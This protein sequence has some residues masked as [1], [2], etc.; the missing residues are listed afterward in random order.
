MTR[1]KQKDRRPVGSCVLE[2]LDTCTH[3]ACRTPHSEWDFDEFDVQYVA[4]LNERRDE[5]EERVK[6]LEAA[7]EKA[8][9]DD[10]RYPMGGP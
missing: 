1:R 9:G 7:L 3:V 10:H 8:T 5:L 6:E 2:G 4:A